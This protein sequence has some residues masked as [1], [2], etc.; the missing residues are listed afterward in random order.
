[1]RFLVVRLSNKPVETCK[2]KR[3]SVETGGRPGNYPGARAQ[4]GPAN[5][6]S[7]KKTYRWG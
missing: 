3:S 5:I 4:K 7:M 1:M 2:Q 6:Q